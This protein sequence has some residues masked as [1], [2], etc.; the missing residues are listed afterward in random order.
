MD[1]KYQTY[2]LKNGL[3]LAHLQVN[4]PVSYCG[5]VVDAGTRDEHI[6]ECGMAHFTEHMLFKG[7]THRR[8][9]QI[10]NRME[11]VGGDV[12]AYTAKEET[13]FY[14]TF[15]SK[16]FA[17]AFELMTDLIF[18][19]TYPPHE[20]K[21]EVE[22][23]LDEI[24]SY[25][26][27]PAEL[28]FDEFENIL[29]QGHSLGHNILGNKR[30]LLSFDTVKGLDFLHRNYAPSRLLFFSMGRNR[31]DKIIA[32]AERFTE[33]IDFLPEERQRIVPD[34]VATSVTKKHKSTHQSHVMIGGRVCSMYDKQRYPLFLLNNILG[35]P[36]MNNR[37]NVSLREKNGLVYDVES[38]LTHYTD[39]GLQSV[40]FGTD[41]KNREQATDLVLKELEKL[42]ENALT[43]LQLSA[44]KK[45][46]EGQLGVSTDNRENLF[47][48]FGKSMLHYG[49]FDTLKE[50]NGRIAAV[51]ASQILEAANEV[52]A[53]DK[54][55]TL[56]YE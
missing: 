21:K 36:G 53:P 4:S 16:D 31:F 30:S 2:T 24:N 14:A 23:I 51:T 20:I 46:A 33:G 55:F 41:P 35:G 22:V 47:L 17:R 15:M 26:D 11:N 25:N 52:Y 9:W 40:Y 56:I 6:D 43:T 13:F 34:E 39:T 38:N 7:T 19:S 18:H 29:Y 48:G 54:L 10:R 3:R 44:A 45:Q 28:I 50:I 27:S 49:R 8:A 5:Y 37:L 32:M 42:R 12:N 1:N